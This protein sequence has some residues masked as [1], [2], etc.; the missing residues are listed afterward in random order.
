MAAVAGGGPKPGEVRLVRTDLPQHDR[1]NVLQAAQLLYKRIV[2]CEDEKSGKKRSKMDRWGEFARALRGSMDQSFGP[3]WH[4]IVG[5][6]VAFACKKRNKTMAVFRVDEIII[7]L[8]CS[9]G[10]EEVGGDE[11]SATE[12]GDNKAEA[13]TDAGG[14]DMPKFR[15]L[16]PSAADVSSDSELER[17]VAAL[18]KEFQAL[19]DNKPPEF[20]SFAQAV[21]KQLTSEL[22]T[23][24]HVSVGNEFVVEPAHNVRNL[25]HAAWGKV[26]VVCFQHEQKLKNTLDFKKIMKAL[27]Y[28]ALVIY[29]FAYMTNNSLCGETPP[30][31]YFALAIRRKFC[32]EDT[33]WNVNAIGIVA[34]VSLFARKKSHLFMGKSKLA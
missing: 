2:G 7:L 21:R 27:P 20:Q 19:P 23:I 26:H 3:Q 6:K 1:R 33:E 17:T 12:S 32:G 31:N 8:W 30:D 18:R 34:L 14:S 11:G 24:W 10:I 22:G 13:E 15:V 16:Q 28:I 5:D 25:V 4:C 9:P 29:C